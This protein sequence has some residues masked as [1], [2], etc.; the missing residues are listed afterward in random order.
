M[1][2][3]KPKPWH[4]FREFLKEYLIIVIGV[5]TAL[6]G[7]QLA[8][9]AH[10]GSEIREAREALHAE[11]AVDTSTADFVLLEVDCLAQQLDAFD[12]WAKGGTRPGDLRTQLPTYAS[13][14]WDVVKTGAVPHMQLKERLAYSSYYDT[15]ENARY[16]IETTRNIYTRLN[17][18]HQL[19]ALGPEE[20][21]RLIEEIG[22]ARVMGR[23]RKA[24]ATRL[25]DGAKALGVEPDHFSP[26]SKAN[27]SRVC[28]RP[29]AG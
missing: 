27:L 22:Q 19:D 9:R 1:E 14:A 6:G 10:R 7:E 21:R 29:I 17:G 3:H 18:L 20:A 25:V 15:V 13:S 28:G 16:A 8:E 12:A 4:G 5:L 23:V 24:N 11:L 26:N 2:I